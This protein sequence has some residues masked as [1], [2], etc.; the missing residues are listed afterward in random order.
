MVTARLLTKFFV[1][2][3]GMYQNLV[4]KDFFPNVSQI[5]ICHTMEFQKRE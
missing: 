1:L 3:K 5:E 4:F 2:S